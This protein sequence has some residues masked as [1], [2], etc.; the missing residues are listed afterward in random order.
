MFAGLDLKDTAIIYTSDHGQALF[1][2]QLTHCSVKAPDPREGLVPLLAMTDIAELKTRFE[3]GAHLNKAKASHFAIRPTVLEL[4]GYKPAKIKQLYGPSLFV[5]GK[6]N[7]QFTSGDVFSVFRQQVRW[8]PLDLSA[9]YV[10]F[11]K[12]PH[13]RPAPMVAIDGNR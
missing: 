7:P 6:V 9:K 3:R 11:D 8:T 10:E 1:N 13:P 2:G 4:M 12:P 5:A